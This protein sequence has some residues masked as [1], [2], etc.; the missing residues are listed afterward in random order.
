[1]PRIKQH[2]DKYAMVDLSAH[3]IGRAKNCGKTQGD[4]GG[5]LNIS[6]Q[7]VSRLLKKPENIKIGTLRKLCKIINIDPEVVLN[8]VGLKKEENDEKLYLHQ[9]SKNRPV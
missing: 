7:A 5:A 6:Q 3:I 4:I 9:R 1:M 2:A 8:A